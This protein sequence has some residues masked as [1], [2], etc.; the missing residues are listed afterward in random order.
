MMN[1]GYDCFL[2]YF[3]EESVVTMDHA[4]KVG[5]Y[6]GFMKKGK[7]QTLADCRSRL[8]AN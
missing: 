1:E 2:V 3:L 8:S 7:Q 4:G 5:R 6:L